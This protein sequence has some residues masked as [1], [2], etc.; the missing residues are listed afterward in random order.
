MRIRVDPDGTVRAVYSDKIKEMNLG[1]L[2]VARASNVEF[3][4][5]DQQWEAR[6]PAGECIAS[7]P[8]RD[9][10]IAAEVRV[11]EARL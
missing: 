8:N 7:G 9:Q 11:I 10:V 5:I 3:N 2:Q 4:T 1:P 6:T